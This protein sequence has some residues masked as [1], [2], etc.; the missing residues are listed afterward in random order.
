MSISVLVVEDHDELRSTLQNM[1]TQEGYDVH[2]AAN[3]DDAIATLNAM[4]PPCLVLWDPIT[5]PMS[6]AIVVRTARQGILVATIPVGITSTGQAADGSPI[7][8]KRLTSRDAILS[9]V[10]EHCPR[11]EQRAA[12]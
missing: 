3:V 7:I 4:P 6:A 2:C 9:V 11:V 1:L 5:L 10:R 8:A 12:E